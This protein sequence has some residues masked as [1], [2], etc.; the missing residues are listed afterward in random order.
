MSEEI[1][2]GEDYI[3]IQPLTKGGMGRLYKAYRIGL[4]VDVVIKRIK[5]RYVGKLDQRAE[6]DILKNLKH[7]Y[8]P[9]IYDIIN[10][11]DGYYYTVMD[12]IPGINL[13]QYIQKNG[14]VCQ[15]LAHKWACQLC[16][17]V[18]YLHEQTPPIIHCDIKPS[19]LMVTSDEN[20]CLIDFN[21]SLIFSDGI[22]AVGATSG[23][24]APEQYTRKPV[25]PSVPLVSSSDPTV[26]ISESDGDL[27]RSSDS[28]SRSFS[29][30]VSSRARFYGAITKK[31]DVYG[32]GATLYYAVTAQT[33]QRALDPVTPISS[34]SLRIGKP[35]QAIIE[36]AMYKEPERRFGDAEQMLHALQ[37]VD[38]MDQRV[39]KYRRL[40]LIST[41]IVCVWI[42]MSLASIGYGILRVRSEREQQ[43][44]TLI[45]QAEAFRQQHQYES[46]QSLLEQALSLYPTRA[47]AY[48]SLAAQ[49]Y[50]QGDYQRSYDLL[51]NA[52]NSGNLRIEN[53]VDQDNADL[54]YIQAS[55]LYEMESYPQ[56]V[57]LYQQAINFEKDSPSYYRGLALAQAHA[58][59]LDEAG[60]TLEILSQ[61]DGSTLDCDIVRAEIH[62]INQQY[63]QAIE[64]YHEIVSQTEDLQILSRVCLSA[65]KICDYLGDTDEQIEWLELAVNRLGSASAIHEEMLADAYC[66]KAQSD[67]TNSAGWYQKARDHLE[68]I[69]QNGQDNILTN[70]NLA[71]VL[72]NLGAFAEAEELLLQAYQAFPSDYRI[73]MR[74][75]FL[76][77][78]WQADFPVEQ[79]DYSRTMQYYQIADRQY[80]TAVANGESD[81]EMSR[82]EALIE[83]LRVSGWIDE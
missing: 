81:I 4:D 33:P 58:G 41:M 32:I 68:H 5:S 60:Q 38:E 54:L 70:L 71:V 3:H 77:A 35:F 73:S 39:R 25:I 47:D 74:L 57:E 52:I 15:K 43:Y 42:L 2:L 9:R 59:Q 49:F 6:A 63:S 7:R 36:R 61:Q 50:E 45:S 76:Y 30:A 21:T 69:I 46:G 56:A 1:Y 19:N 8:L 55:C 51:Q 65:A 79:R 24:A 67:P 22:L 82:L 23:Y 16:E 44:L 20:I 80:A 62:T 10:G 34:Y 40:R 83:Q 31:T 66:D 18:A 75:A 48:L 27:F 37:D 17:V 53:L 78:D 14:P 26:L 12:F 13:Q 64:L 28:L 11:G 72:Q 29:V